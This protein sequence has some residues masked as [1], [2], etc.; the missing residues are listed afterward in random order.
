MTVGTATAAVVG[1][2]GGP[3]GNS[4]SF[5]IHV[6][7]TDMSTTRTYSVGYSFGGTA[8]GGGVDHNG[9]SGSADVTLPA[10]AYTGSSDTITVSTFTDN[11]VEGDE[12]LRFSIDSV[13]GPGGGA[14]GTP[15]SATAT[16]VDR[17]PSAA[18]AATSA[19]ASEDGSTGQF[20]VTRTDGK[21]SESLSVNLA[22][23]GTASP[24]T[25]Y[26]S[27]P[28]SVTIPANASSYSFSVVPIDDEELEDT[29]TVTAAVAPGSY[30]VPS[31][32]AVTVDIAQAAVAMQ[33]G[34]GVNWNAATD[35]LTVARPASGTRTAHMILSAVTASGKK[36]KDVGIDYEWT[37]Q[38]P[39]VLPNPT[40][41]NP[42]PGD[43]DGTGA[44][45]QDDITID[46]TNQTTPGTY[47]LKFIALDKRVAPIEITI[48]IQ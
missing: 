47:K 16:I 4:F 37:Q 38:P 3:E 9:V 11:L 6:N 31:T 36:I 24:G 5:K 39:L 21:V 23:G 25:D 19:A 41:V 15:G 48:V 28:T 26:G 2:S 17:P 10:F 30:A 45:G 18:V 35:T 20:T 7:N 33:V 44:T 14:I 46:V 32:G 8:S 22:Y 34:G 13:S 40:V 42:V 1:S 12:T 43:I 29:E 27:L